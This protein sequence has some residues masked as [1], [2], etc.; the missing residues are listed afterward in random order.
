MP[1]KVSTSQ[2][3][4]KTSNMILLATGWFQKTINGGSFSSILTI[5]LKSNCLLYKNLCKILL[6]FFVLGLRIICFLGMFENMV[7]SWNVCF[8]VG[9]PGL[10][11]WGGQNRISQSGMW[12]HSTL[13]RGYRWWSWLCHSVNITLWGRAH[14]ERRGY[15]WWSCGAVG[16]RWICSVSLNS[17]HIFSSLHSYSGKMRILKVCKALRAMQL[18]FE[19]NHHTTFTPAG[20]T[21]DGHQI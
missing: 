17:T 15:L 14:S 20:P 4:H 21:D 16:T 2:L 10:S 5:R 1:Q 7:F 8:W 13:E 18:Y 11:D 9:S 6:S 3:C 12:G 19:Y